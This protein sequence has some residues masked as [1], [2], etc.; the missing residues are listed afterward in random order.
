[1]GENPLLGEFS[2]PLGLLRGLV[3]RIGPPPGGFL[4]KIGNMGAPSF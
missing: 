4:G 1:L 2:G 3:L